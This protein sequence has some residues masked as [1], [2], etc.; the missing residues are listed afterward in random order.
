MIITPCVYDCRLLLYH[1]KVNICSHARF[2]KPMLG[3][4]DGFALQARHF[5][6]RKSPFW[7]KPSSCGAVLVQ[8]TCMCGCRLVLYYSKV[9]IHSLE[10]IMKPRMGIIDGCLLQHHQLLPSQ[11]SFRKLFS[12]F[13]AVL[14]Q[15]THVEDFRL[16]LYHSKVN[17]NSYESFMKPE[18]GFI[19]GFLLQSHHFLPSKS[20]F[21]REIE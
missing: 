20:P 1:S 4:I 12:N 13:V 15:N 7:R 19:D 6:V 16:L 14:T 17:N 9:N 11:S 5:L 18:M 21:W 10:R 8:K 2:M 3:I